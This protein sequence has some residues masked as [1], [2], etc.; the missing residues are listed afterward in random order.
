MTKTKVLLFI[1][2]KAKP[3][4]FCRLVK[5]KRQVPVVHYTPLPKIV[6]HKHDHA[7]DLILLTSYLADDWL[8]DEFGES[9]FRVMARDQKHEFYAPSKMADIWWIERIWGAMMTKVYKEPFPRTL[10]GFRRRVIVAW[11]SFDT[12]RVTKMIH[13][14][15]AR[16]EWISKNK[17]KVIPNSWDYSVSVLA[18]DCEICGCHE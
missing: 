4:R 10:K 9:R 14:T 2:G 16:L 3:R 17:G 6:T 8:E 18:C 15:P 5:R 12:D 13:E 1:M 11:N 7:R